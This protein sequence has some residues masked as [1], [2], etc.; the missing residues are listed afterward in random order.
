M[1]LR[2]WLTT[3]TALILFICLFTWWMRKAGDHPL[4]NDE[5]YSQTSSIAHRSYVEMLSGRI[6]EGNNTP[7][8]YVV[9]KTIENV[10]AYQTPPEWYKGQWNFRHHASQLFLRLFPVFCMALGITLVFYY[11]AMHWHFF[12]GVYAVLVSLTS[13]MVWAYVCQ[14]RP[15]ALW[16]FLTVVQIVLLLRILVVKPKE[17]GRFSLGLVVVNWLLAF[18]VIFSVVQ[19]LAVCGVLWLW[20]RRRLRDHILLLL[21]PFGIA[22]FY[23]V[24]S[25]KYHFWFAEG[26]DKLLGAA[27]PIDRLGTIMLA[28]GVWAISKAGWFKRFFAP[29]QKTQVN[30]LSAGLLFGVIVYV[31][32]LAVLY[33]FK[34]DARGYMDGFQ[35]SNRYF[36]VLAPTGIFLTSF[37]AYYLAVTPKGIVKNGA[38]IL[39]AV[40]LLFRILRTSWFS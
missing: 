39:L 7:L 32:C 12:L 15:Y 34:I 2:K 8:F 13:Y 10:A 37:A 27:L 33:K 5:L 9:Q 17:Q 38:W 20:G 23:Y 26:F 16:F 4:E 18:T 28:L 29:P 11:F 24:H 25:P 30:V 40:L 31:G 6:D 36:M 14:A 35:V 1:T 22:M 19:N 3:G 21:V